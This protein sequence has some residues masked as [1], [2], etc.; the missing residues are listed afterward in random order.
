[1]ELKK[2]NKVSDKN[3]S[4]YYFNKLNSFVKNLKRV[5]F[6]KAKKNC[7]R[8]NHAHKICNQ[9]FFSL[10]DKIEI[11]IDNG[12]VQKKIILKPSHILKIKPLNWVKIK[13]KKNQLVGVFCDTDYSEKEYIRNYVEFK[14][15]IKKQ[16]KK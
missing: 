2:I 14:K 12:K 3:C 8:G 4:L 13:L 11:F 6:L 9:Y 10:D 16:K 1:M 15:K 7:F 5:F